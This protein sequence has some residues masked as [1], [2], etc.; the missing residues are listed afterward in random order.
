M[1]VDA[2]ALVAIL[3]GEPDAEALENRL[4]AS[5]TTLIISPLATF[6]SVVAVSRRLRLNVHEAGGAVST[7]VTAVGVVETAITSE[8]GRLAL[9]ARARY[10]K[11]SGHP[12]QLNL[13]DCFSYACAKAHAVPLL[14]KGDDF[15]HT[16][17]A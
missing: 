14:Y 3:T 8:I 5:P 10:G 6:E 13:G 4:F 2:S 12:A 11:G 16:D 15:I 17:L 1:F 7:Y 9:L